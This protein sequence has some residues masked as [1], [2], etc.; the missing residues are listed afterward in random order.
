MIANH[1]HDALGQVR[2]LQS[3]ILE[4]RK[5][6]GFSGTARMLGGSVAFLVCA[7]MSFVDDREDLQLMGWGLIL[8]IALT[9]NFGAL[10]LWFI[11][12]PR[13]KRVASAMLP[14]GESV[15]P[16][17]IGAVL[18]LALLLKGYT[19]L[20]FGSWMC[21]YGLAHTV[22]RHCLP[23]SI[24]FLGIYYMACGTV[25]LLWP[26]NVFMNPLPAGCVFLV[27][28]WTGGVVFH[29]HK[30]ACMEEIDDE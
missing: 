23:R 30:T 13:R 22:Y 17:A 1:I 28:E 4:K 18:T 15:P 5:F 29:R 19:D 27:G 16:L 26:G 21:L 9:L 10:F 11:Q 25:F 12:L 14:A 6:T 2:R 3:L 7:L 8:A 24:W 20:L